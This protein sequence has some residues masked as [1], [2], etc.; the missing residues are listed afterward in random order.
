MQCSNK[1]MHLPTRMRKNASK[2]HPVDLTGRR[3]LRSLGG[4]DKHSKICT[5]KGSRDRRIRLSANT[6]IQ[7]Y[8]V[9]DRLGFDRPS[10]AIDWLMKEAKAA[11]DV[12][13]GDQYHHF[14]ELLVPDATN[15][16]FN[17]SAAFH[18]TPGVLVQQNLN[19]DQI[20]GFN[21]SQFVGNPIHWNPDYNESE[22]FEFVN[23][24]PLQSSF[25]TQ[26]ADDVN[27]NE[28]YGLL[29]VS[30]DPEIQVQE[31]EVE[32]NQDD[33]RYDQGYMF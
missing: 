30:F 33:R 2:E 14:H 4:K 19:Q 22:G 23:R 13:N 15:S 6:A 3:V 29:G 26:V 17:V 16:I 1:N 27:N 20:Y 8:D 10:N 21:K 24:E 9:Q 12:L 11:I 28:S 32:L 18:R 5:S 25:H 7:F 31:A